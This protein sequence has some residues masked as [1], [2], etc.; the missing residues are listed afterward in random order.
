MKFTAPTFGL[1]LA[2]HSSIARGATAVF[3]STAIGAVVTEQIEFWFNTVP[4]K[5]WDKNTAADISC[6]MDPATGGSCSAS[7]GY[8]AS[9]TYGMHKLC[10]ESFKWS[11]NPCLQ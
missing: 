5:D 3:M 6:V 9:G 11:P 2:F 4:A 10:V 8:S 7:N 1:I